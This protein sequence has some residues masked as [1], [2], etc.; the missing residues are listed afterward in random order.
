MSTD[1]R[2][3][4]LLGAAAL[5]AT[6]P[7]AAAQLA[8]AWEAYAANP[9]AHPNI[10]NVSHAGYKGADAP[11][12]DGSG[13]VLVSVTNFGAVGDGVA[14]DTAAVRAAIAQ[15]ASQAGQQPNGSTVLFPP[16]VYRLTGPLLVHDDRVQL[17]GVGRDDVTLLF[18]ASLATS[19]A[20]YPG[21]TPDRS[22]WSFSGGL[23]WFTDDSR[24]PYLAGVPTITGIGDGWRIT[25]KRD[26]TTPASVGD[27]AIRV[28]NASGIAAGDV[29]ALEIDNANDLSTLRHLLGDGAWANG[30]TFTSAADG[31]VLPAQR[32]AFRVYHTVETVVG[33]LLV[34]REPLRFDLRPEWDPE[35]GI[36]QDLRRDVGVADLT[37]QMNRDYEWTRRD[38][39]NNEQ[40]W[41]AIAFSDTVDGF[42][43]NLR[44]V[45]VDGLAITL[46]YSKNITVD[47]VIVDSTG[48]DR[49]E[50]H[51]AF[52]IA[53]TSD[54]VIQNFEVRSRPLHGLY[55]G[56]VAAGNVYAAG[57][58]HNGTFDY[59][60]LLPFANVF[61]DVSIFN[62]GSAGGAADSGPRTGARATHWNVSANRTGSNLIAEP[63][64][65][66]MGAL[67]GVRCCV[68]TPEVDPAIGDAE[69]LI[70]STGYAARSVNPPNLY[71]AQIALRK[72]D[73]IPTAP[74]AP[75]CAECQDDEP[76]AFAFAGT[77]GANLVGQDNWRFERDFTGADGNNVQLVSLA[78]HPDGPTL[79][80]QSNAGR[81]SVVSRHNNDRYAFFPHDRD[82]G[83]AVIRFDARAGLPGG[84]AGNVYLILNNAADTGLQFGM[85]D[86]EFLVRG[87]RFSGVLQE[88]AAVPS[89]WYDR[90]EWARLELRCDFAANNGDGACSLFFRNISRGETTYQPVAGL[91]NV[92]LRGEVRDPETWDL[93]EFRIR[94]DAAA[95]NIVPNDAALARCCIADLDGDGAVTTG[96]DVNPFLALLNAQDPAADLTADGSV[97]YLDLAAFLQAAATGCG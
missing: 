68:P 8:D 91:Q 18:D 45:D 71:L 29:V 65:M 79:A 35:V 40:G 24:N 89:S 37:I 26:V 42:A 56:N 77:L 38:W 53:N 63:A 13:T 16:G 81:D 14:D 93:I 22:N 11:I 47:G 43:S 94:N 50:H 19:Y 5:A 73:A 85:R 25:N 9:D 55:V 27:R 31:A 33:N 90:G 51:H 48:P 36:P 32:S 20:E 39:H 21:S 95:A 4:S 44:I 41:N 96:G 60:K 3:F 87:G 64:I 78:S 70:E 49:V 30:Y 6:A 7:A 59:H 10:P 80:M 12:P 66:P 86:S 1:R 15:A 61:T 62:N 67:V 28:T 84:G 75:D 82:D 17:R 46:S 34:L 92:D 97:D 57:V 83:H 23:L 52:T 74:P 69:T 88:T 58:M 54:C 72:G 76:Y 2:L